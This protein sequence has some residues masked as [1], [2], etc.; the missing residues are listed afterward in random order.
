M[1]F[2]QLTV[3]CPMKQTCDNP[4]CAIADSG[5]DLQLLSAQLEQFGTVF[6]CEVLKPLL[7]TKDSTPRCT[8][9]LN[10]LLLFTTVIINREYENIHL[11]CEYI[12][13]G[14]SKYEIFILDKVFKLLLL[15]NKYNKR[16][17]IDLMAINIFIQFGS[18]FQMR[19]PALILLEGVFKNLEHLSEI[20]TYGIEFIKNKV[21]L[22]SLKKKCTL[23]TPINNH[24]ILKCINIIKGHLLSVS[25][26]PLKPYP[27]ACFL[28]EILENI[29]TFN[30][31]YKICS[32][33]HFHLS[34]FIDRFDSKVEIRQ[35]S[36]NKISLLDFSFIFPLEYKVE[37]LTLL[38]KEKQRHALQRSF[39]CA[40]FEGPIPPYLCMK[41]NRERLF[42][43][44]A[45]FL[46]QDNVEYDKQLRISFKGEEGVDTGGLTKEYFMLIGEY[47]KN[48]DELFKERKG[49]ILW[50]S[51]NNQPKEKYKIVGILLG[52][53]FYNSTILS[54]SFPPVFYKLLLDMDSISLSDLYDL[55]PEIA[56][57]L[58]ALKKLSDE[59]IKKLQLD[60]TINY[61]G[62][63]HTLKEDTPLTPSNVDTY[64]KLYYEYILKE[65]VRG[66]L[67]SIREGFLSTL[68]EKTLHV[69]EADELE[70]ILSGSEKV[71]LELLKSKTRYVDFS[72]Q[73]EQ[74]VWLWEALEEWSSE[75]LNRL[76][77]FITGS[78][79]VPLC[80]LASWE[81]VITKNGADTDRLPS[82]QTCFNTL[83]LPLY[84]TKEKLNEKLRKAALYC[85]GF[86]LF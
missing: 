45:H 29:Y 52:L 77:E 4:F 16:Q 43:D 13:S 31:K 8:K 12:S 69:L 14:L 84:C 46:L 19:E 41:I 3:G 15:S 56:S 80:L 57:S 17:D 67:E 86:Y 26:D 85:K 2:D 21:L 33:T 20:E 53:S 38:N 82:S 60:F 68:S 7:R 72:P 73:S 79:R 35:F 10:R 76:V 48:E 27:I 5:F 75:E 54:L 1:Y 83:M 78:P 74:V 44:S 70:N 63:T 65:S 61:S 18:Q 50:F 42:D 51:G 55:E 30:K 49:G 32:N 28:L 34:E 40:L 11:L 6:K 22:N 62:N 39:F 58:N 66:P 81:L 71:C 36:S 47:I 37:Y 59:D 24:G 9:K 25:I 64:I 23:S